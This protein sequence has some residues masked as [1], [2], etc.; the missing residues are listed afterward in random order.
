MCQIKNSQGKSDGI[1]ELEKHILKISQEHRD[2]KRAFAFALIVYDFENPHLNKILNDKGYY[3]A[4]DYISGKALTVFY[5][6]SDYLDCQSQ[7]A[8]ESNQMI[9]ELSMQKINAPENVSPKFL[10]EKLINK[11]SL[12]SP[13]KL[14]LISLSIDLTTI[15]Q[16]SLS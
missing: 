2:N 8:K 12:P 1:E 16:Y 10:A 15:F 3:N 11:E 6:N 13:S 9:V 14:F 5:V 4:L 7:K